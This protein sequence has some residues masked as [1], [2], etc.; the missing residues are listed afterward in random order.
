[1]ST[2][3]GTARERAAVLRRGTTALIFDLYGTIVDMQ[4]GLTE[5]A[6]PYLEEK[7]W[8][9]EDGTNGMRAPFSVESW[10]TVMA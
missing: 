2:D 4:A 9:G 1:M 3:P 8:D 10:V 6:T 5:A 7:G